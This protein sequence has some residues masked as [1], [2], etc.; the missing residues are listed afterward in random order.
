M[1]NA[2]VL[3]WRLRP[4]V[5]LQS[6]A[7]AGGISAVAAV[8]PW[9]LM[10][11]PAQGAVTAAL[12]GGFALWRGWQGKEILRYRQ[13]LKFQRLTYMAPHKIPVGRDDLYLGHGFEFTQRHTQ[14][15]VDAAHPSAEP[16]VTPKAWEIRA[17][18]FASELRG[19]AL[20]TIEKRTPRLTAKAAAIRPLVLATLA[21]AI[22]VFRVRSFAAFV[23]AVRAAE[24]PE[25]SVIDAPQ[26]APVETATPAA[27]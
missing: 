22:L 14:R 21:V 2:N 13:G 5:E 12:A 9:A 10:M 27:G 1:S 16:F 3:D 26:A 7:V 4:A 24:T 8:A 20:G 18:K 6:A 17:R 19:W 23:F 25:P 11:Q 15:L